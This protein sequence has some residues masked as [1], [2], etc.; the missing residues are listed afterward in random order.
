MIKWRGDADID[1][2][3]ECDIMF[4]MALDDGSSY[5]AEP[6]QLSAFTVTDGDDEIITEE[7]PSDNESVFKEECEKY[8]VTDYKLLRACILYDSPRSTCEKDDLWLATISSI[9]MY[10]ELN[11]WVKG[12]VLDYNEDDI[13]CASKVKLKDGSYKI[14]RVEDINMSWLEWLDARQSYPE[15]TEVY[16]EMF[17]YMEKFKSLPVCLR[18]VKS[19]HVAHAYR[20]KRW[21]VDASVL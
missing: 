6:L 10:V 8:G 3:N 4:C 2:S 18:L 11:S 9:R 1:V 20:M 15:C 14:F 12:H 13:L 19:E 16:N 21:L 5:A 7:K 17:K